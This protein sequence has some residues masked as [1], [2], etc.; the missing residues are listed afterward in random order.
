MSYPSLQNGHAPVSS[1]HGHFPAF[2]LTQPVSRVL[3]QP[4]K[5]PSTSGAT[6][7]KAPA[8]KHAHHLHT[9][10]PREKSTRTLIIDHML[11]VHGRTRSAQARAELGMTDLTG[12]P[13]SPNYCFRERPE[14]YEEEEEIGSDGESIGSLKAR[15]A[16]GPG[17]THSEDED[18]RMQKQNLALARNLRLRAIALEKV[19][20]SMLDQPPPLH[21]VL[22]DELHTPPTSPKRSEFSTS[23]A[24]HPHTL[25]NGVRL[26]LA[27]GTLINDLFAR[28]AP[29]E[30]YRH[31]HHPP[32]IIVSTRNSDQGSS[33]PLSPGSPV[34]PT[35]SPHPS[36]GASSQS[37]GGVTGTLPPSLL[38]L[39]SISGAAG[40]QPLSSNSMSS[41][42][43]LVLDMLGQHNVQRRIAPVLT[44]RVRGLYMAGADPSTANSP[45]TLRCPRHLHTGCEIC[46]EAKPPAKA[47]GGP[48]RGRGASGS[49]WGGEATSRPP[50]IGTGKSMGGS[51]GGITGW[52]DGSGIGSGLAQPGING[53]VLRRKP[54]W[55]HQDAEDDSG[56][57]GSGA[58]NIRLSEFIPRFLRLS[59]LVAM[60]LGQELWDEEPERDFQGERSSMGIPFLTPASPV[61]PFQ[62]RKFH[63]ESEVAPLRPSREWYMLFAG[64]LTRAALEGYLAGGWRGPDAAACLLSVGLGISDDASTSDD[65]DNG[66]TIFD[67][68]EPD[69]LPT[70]KE[71]ARIM[72]PALRATAGGMPPRRE[73][74]EAEFEAEMSE[75][76]RRF[77]AIPSLTPDLSTHMEDLAW[78]YPAEPV[79]R[80]AVRFCEA[81][82]KWRGKPELEGVRL[83]HPMESYHL[84]SACLKYKKKPK[85]PATPGLSSMTIE[86]LVHSNP[87]S[88]STGAFPAQPSPLKPKRPS[89][90]HY[91]IFPQ[92]LTGRKRRRSVDDGDRFRKRVH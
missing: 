78:H 30:P 53:S 72:F 2:S 46:V 76:L 12:G 92:P 80:V 26:R 7:F 25:P 9:I 8:H 3:P 87:T 68:F 35:P 42:T 20:T 88:P 5:P 90:E 64:L 89:I 81:I 84:I 69:D 66:D 57:M 63:S 60:E 31:H 55:L 23:K 85:E 47:P 48:P 83:L 1:I 54:K 19:V 75:R 40:R 45:P 4:Q 14:Q 74:A 86:S 17:H 38:L 77:Y 24:S 58:G 70:V 29:T 28:Q 56:H 27:L 79:E 71:A 43:P 82:A 91:F 50:K 13:S 44:G 67:W 39:S 65:E 21:P 49:A 33:D 18:A 51:G 10:P 11:W 6:S 62:A 37:S 36:I 34:L 59:A 15:E 61:S 16:A 41:R 22:D 32:P 73:N 52:Q